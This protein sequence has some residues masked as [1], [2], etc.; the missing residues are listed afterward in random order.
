M[1]LENAIILILI[2]VIIVVAGFVLLMNVGG[3]ATGEVK[4][5]V[6]MF[7]EQWLLVLYC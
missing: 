3:M 7:Q 4:G 5:V 1:K 2:V 6:I